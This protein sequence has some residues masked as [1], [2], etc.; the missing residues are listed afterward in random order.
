MTWF[1]DSPLENEG[2]LQA[3][4]APEVGT[5]S[6]LPSGQEWGLPVFHSGPTSFIY[7]FYFHWFRIPLPM[8]YWEYLTLGLNVLLSELDHMW[9][10]KIIPVS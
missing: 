9:Q 1:Y 3:L 2:G 6:D 8:Y 5:E 7:F 4:K 10:V